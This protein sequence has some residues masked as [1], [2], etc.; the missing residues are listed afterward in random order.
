MDSDSSFLPWSGQFPANTIAIKQT[1]P[2]KSKQKP[3]NQLRKIHFA[4]YRTA[5][6]LGEHIGHPEK[7]HASKI[8]KKKV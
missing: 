6:T 1:P 4:L 7:S 8:K 5:W 2:T 3:H